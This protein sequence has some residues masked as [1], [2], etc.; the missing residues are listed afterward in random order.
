MIMII[1]NNFHSFFYLS[2]LKDSIEEVKDISLSDVSMEFSTEFSTAFSNSAFNS[3]SN[4]LFNS[5][6]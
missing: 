1:I 2:L 5:S 4:A 3:R 6:S